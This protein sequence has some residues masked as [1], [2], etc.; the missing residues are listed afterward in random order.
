MNTKITFQSA[1]KPQIIEEG[2]E[3]IPQGSTLI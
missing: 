2:S 1:A 3:T